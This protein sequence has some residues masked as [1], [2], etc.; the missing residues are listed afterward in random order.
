M[1]RQIPQAS[2]SHGAAKRIRGGVKRI[3]PVLSLSGEEEHEQLAA[4]I[5]DPK[6]PEEPSSLL[7][8]CRE[9]LAQLLRRWDAK[10]AKHGHTTQEL[11][12]ILAEEVDKLVAEKQLQNSSALEASARYV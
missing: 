5:S 2:S 3:R 8:I 7:A 10:L 6:Q 11:V 12:E 1:K 4:S 9:Y